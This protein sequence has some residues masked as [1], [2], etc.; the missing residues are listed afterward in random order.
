MSGKSYRAAMVLV[1]RGLE[2]V[3][4]RYIIQNRVNWKIL[5]HFP[6]SYLGHTFI[7]DIDTNFKY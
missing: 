1:E 7:E 3:L 2:S 6:Y 5:I 4:L